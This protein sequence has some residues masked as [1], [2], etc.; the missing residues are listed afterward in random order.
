MIKFGSFYYFQET[1][2]ETS[3]IK[4]T[5]MD[6]IDE[7]FDKECSRYIC[8][9]CNYSSKYKQNLKRHMN[10]HRQGKAP[11]PVSDTPTKQ[12]LKTCHSCSICNYTSSR[13]SNFTRHLQVHE[14]DERLKKTKEIYICETCGK[15]FKSKF[16]LKLHTESIH[17]KKFKFSCPTCDRGFN[18]FHQ[19]RGHMASHH[20]SL[21][22]KCLLC[23]LTFRYKTSLN[24]HIE[25]VHKQVKFAC[26]FLNCDVQCSSNRALI[27]HVRAKHNKDRFPC[28]KC[29]KTFKWR[30]SLKYHRSRFHKE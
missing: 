3:E 28:D 2:N 20:E 22:E 18:Q 23:S 10:I 15:Q 17:L 24:E 19:F 1:P 21:N 16:A 26:S 6:D 30:S 27:E 13:K 8:K 12:K 9:V 4:D 11:S 7:S 14:T 5:E 29:D 25:S